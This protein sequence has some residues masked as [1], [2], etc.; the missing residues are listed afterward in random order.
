MDKVHSKVTTVISI[1]D[2]LLMTKW[3]EL[4]NFVGK[5][6]MFTLERLRSVCNFKMKVL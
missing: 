3:K 6:V 4:A 2:R 5:M 1:R